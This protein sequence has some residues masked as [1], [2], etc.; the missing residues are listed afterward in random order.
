[1]RIPVGDRIVMRGQNCHAKKTT[2][3]APKKRR[4]KKKIKKSKK[5]KKHFLEKKTINS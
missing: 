4:L 3:L 1:V 5:S 2:K